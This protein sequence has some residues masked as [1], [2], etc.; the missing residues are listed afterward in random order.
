M[1]W[2]VKKGVLENI[3]EFHRKTPVLE[4]LFNKVAGLRICNFVKKRLQNR[5]FP[6]KFSNFLRILILRN[7]C[8][9]LLLK[10]VGTQKR[11]QNPSNNLR[12]NFLRNI[13]QTST[14]F[15]KRSDTLYWV[16]DTPLVL[17]NSTIVNSYNL[18]DTSYNVFYYFLCSPKSKEDFIFW[19]MSLYR[20]L[21]KT[22]FSKCPIGLIQYCIVT[23][24]KYSQ[25]INTNPI[26]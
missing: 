3:S 26:P 13:F 25:R 18:I 16:L 19:E 15:A 14:I 24:R 21:T 10:V 4:S 2:S 9:R 5:C 6:M 12:W 8:E 20:M 17:N 11:I 7:F 23:R 22:Q 1:S